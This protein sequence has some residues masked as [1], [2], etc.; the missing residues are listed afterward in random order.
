[1][2]SPAVNLLALG[3]GGSLVASITVQSLQPSDASPADQVRSQLT[4]GTLPVSVSYFPT[5]DASKPEHRQLL[6]SSKTSLA[7][8]VHIG[9]LAGSTRLRIGTLD[10]NMPERDNANANSGKNS[11]TYNLWLANTQEGWQLEVGNTARAAAVIPLSH[12]LVDESVSTL[13]ASFIPTA[14]DAGHLA[15]RWGVHQWV[16]DFH[17]AE[18]SESLKTE[19]GEA[20]QNTN[21]VTRQVFDADTSDS[22]RQTRLGERHETAIELPNE[23]R[24]SV[25]FWRN[26][27]AEHG[28]FN[29][30][31][32]ATDGDLIELTEAGVIR[33]KN[34]VALRFG[35]VTIPTGN[36]APDYPGLYGLWL[37]RSGHKWRLV[38]NHEAD[39]WGTQHDPQFDATEIE[40]AYSQNESSTRPLGAA[41]I[42]TGIDTGRLVIHWGPHKWSA[43]FAV[44]P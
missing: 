9:G 37:K 31:A 19:A 36:L 28:D 7:S 35:H 43:D 44:V 14:E 13:S 1:M 30:V 29:G 17:F 41:L 11:R 33:L 23:T 6:S 26:I 32:T 18:P 8:P 21:N 12:V 15:L 40:L 4:L 16:A 20:P 5:L 38:F 2:R 42:L 24:I 22:Y 39:S 3:L 10:G 34:S 27:S 25:L